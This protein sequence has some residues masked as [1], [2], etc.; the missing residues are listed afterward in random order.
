MAPQ[1]TDFMDKTS[2]QDF[3]YSLSMLLVFI[4]METRR[5]HG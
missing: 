4:N 2:F 3:R 5:C 1:V